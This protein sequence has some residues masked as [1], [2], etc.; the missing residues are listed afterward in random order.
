MNLRIL[1]NTSLSKIEK[2]LK[3]LLLLDYNI[4]NNLLIDDV[5][6]KMLIMEN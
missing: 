3:S 6:I 4:K 5:A 1:N 2:L